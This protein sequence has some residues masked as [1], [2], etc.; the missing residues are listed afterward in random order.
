MLSISFPSVLRAASV[1]AIIAGLLLLASLTPFFDNILL[2]LLIAG[3]LLVPIGA[4]MYYGYLAPGEESSFQ[5]IVGGALS[6]LLAG[7]ILGLA[8]GLN[9]L[10]RTT[11]TTGLLGAAIAGSAG[12]F[13]MTGGILGVVGAILGGVGGLLWKFTQRPWAEAG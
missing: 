10:L 12:V 2:V 7:F 9:T 6:G 1:A 5:S 11:I 3:A 4:G 13:I 8:F